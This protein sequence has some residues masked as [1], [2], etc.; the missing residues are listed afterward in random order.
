M[1]LFYFMTEQQQWDFNQRNTDKKSFTE[2]KNLMNN[3]Q[4]NNTTEYSNSTSE[5]TY[6]NY[7]FNKQQELIKLRKTFQEI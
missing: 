2:N 1:I 6:A 3:I 4:R 7:L 5:Q